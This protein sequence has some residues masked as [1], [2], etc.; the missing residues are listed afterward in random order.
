MQHRPWPTA[1]GAV[2]VLL[3]LSVPLL[4]IR[5]GFGDYGNY[6]EETTVRRA[7]DLIADG[8]GPGANGP[9]FITVTGSAAGDPAELAAFVD[10]RRD[11]VVPASGGDA[12]VGGAGEI[13][14]MTPCA[15]PID[16]RFTTG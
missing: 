13:A 10:R 15:A 12:L 9:L 3:V 7:Y 2:L 8:F 16:S 1:V 6:P 14:T 4:A 11:D 5:L